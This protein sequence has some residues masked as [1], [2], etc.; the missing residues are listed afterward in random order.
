MSNSPRTF[1]DHPGARA[2]VPVLLGIMGP[3]GGGKTYSALRLATGIQR[4]SGGD[5]GVIDTEASRAL[6]YADYFRFR[7]MDFKAPF[8]SLD[9]LAAIRHF[10]DKGVKTIVVDSMTHEHSGAG[11]YL[12]YAESELDRMAGDNWGKR[13]ACKLA[14]FIKPSQ[15]RR[16]M[17]DGILQLKANVIFNFRAKEKV[18]PMKREGKT[19]IENIGFMPIGSSELVFEMTACCLLMPHAGGVPT[20]VSDVVGEKMMIKTARQFTDIFADPQ[21]LSE[22]IGQKI[23]EW[24]QGKPAAPARDFSAEGDNAA[25]QGLEALKAWWDTVP[26]ADRVPLKDKLAAWKKL[27]ETPAPATESTTAQADAP[28]GD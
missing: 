6:H 4:V 2:S 13:Q 5:I 9:Y 23:A 8:R 1:E 26:K 3:A 14:S 17:I 11:G 27:A 25:G 24:A 19:E 12:E 20:W 18:K 16:A 10:V 21:P 28:F 7:H 22:D 15:E